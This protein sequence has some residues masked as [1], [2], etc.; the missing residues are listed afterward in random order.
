MCTVEITSNLSLQLLLR[1]L[2]L[3]PSLLWKDHHRILG[4]DAPLLIQ[5]RE[6]YLPILSAYREVARLCKVS[7]IIV[8]LSLSRLMSL[9]KMFGLNLKF[10]PT[11]ELWYLRQKGSCHEGHMLSQLTSL[12]SRQT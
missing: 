8:G 1:M 10:L 12:T 5:H 4:E 3:N 6:D 2:D 11:Q 7:Q 9:F